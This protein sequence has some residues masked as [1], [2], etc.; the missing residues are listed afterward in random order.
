MLERLEGIDCPGLLDHGTERGLTYIAM[1]WC[2]GVSIAVAAQQVRATR[3][4]NRLRGLVSR[5]LDA[6]GRLHSRGVLHGD[7][8]P[9]NCL[10][11]DDGRVVILDFGNARLIDSA[12]MVVDPARAGIPQFYDAQMAAA[13]LAGRL[14]PVATP[15]SE[16]YAIAVL[17][18]LL[19]TGLH[20]IEAPAIQE[21]LLRRIV[22]RPPLPFAA[23]GIAAWPD[24]EAVVQ[25]ALS[26]QPDQRF[27]DVA[28]FARAFASADSP[29]GVPRRHSAAQGAFEAAVEAVRNL[30]PG[31]DSPLDNAWFGLRAALALE[32]AEVLAAADILSRRAGSGW[33]AQSVA[34]HLARARSDIGME[35]KAIAEFLKA[36]EPLPDR[37][38]VAAAILAAASIPEDPALRT[39]DGTALGNWAAQR[40]N[41]LALAASSTEHDSWI[42]APL[43]AYTELSLGKSGVIPVPA[44]LPA[45]LEALMH[46]QPHDVWLWSLAHDVFADERYKTLALAARLPRRPL[47]RG[48]ALLRLHQL[49]GD[50]RWVIDAHGALAR[51]PNARLPAQDTVLLMTELMAPERAILPPY[52]LT[53]P[54]Q[55]M[56]RNKRSA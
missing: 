41:R 17:A 47:W 15:T 49:T 30:V 8:H 43:L 48:F 31:I 20:P 37:P 35:S 26:K 1:E 42:A 38:Q 18:Y 22:E 56:H 27:P 40:L 33:A 23:R 16:Q 25:R 51:A 54:H 9:G 11:R 4:R 24:V 5:M 32:D 12:A 10:M 46:T 34:A 45:R 28:T 52:Q 39:A 50:S 6:Y 19:L 29:P 21:E 2:D 53:P 36:A 14:P 55:G 7:I 13:L 3:D 44:D